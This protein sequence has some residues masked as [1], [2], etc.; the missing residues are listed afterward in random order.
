NQIVAELGTRIG[1]AVLSNGFLFFRNFQ[2]LDRK[3]DLAGGAMELRH[4]AI[5][6]VADGETLRALVATV[7]GQFRTADEGGHIV[8]ANR[9]LKA[10]LGHGS[11]RAGNDRTL[12]DVAERFHRVATKLLD[13]ERDALLLRVH[14]EPDRFHD[15]ALRVAGHGLFAGPVPDWL[16]HI[17]PT[18]HVG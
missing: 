9:H 14:L 11:H 13:A 8:F 17:D 5:D 12:A 18:F 7:A 16:G 6:L 10:V 15:L 2:R 4:A 1:G 3:L